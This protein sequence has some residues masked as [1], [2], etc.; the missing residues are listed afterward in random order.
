LAFRQENLKIGVEG[1]I[2]LVVDSQQSVDWAKAGDTK[3]I[4]KE[5]WQSLIKAAK[6][7]SKKILSFLGYKPATPSSSAK[8]EV[9]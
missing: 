8:P 9:K 5:R 6:P 3:K 4:S 2:T 1:T 7:H